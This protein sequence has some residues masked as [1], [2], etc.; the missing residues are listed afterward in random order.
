MTPVSTSTPANLID[1][2]RSLHYIDIANRRDFYTAALATLIINREDMELFTLLFNQYWDSLETAEEPVDPEKK[3]G[4]RRC[5]FPRH[6]AGTAAR[7]RR[8]R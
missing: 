1:L 3:T 2:S 6:K 8:K 4:E 7:R 5:R